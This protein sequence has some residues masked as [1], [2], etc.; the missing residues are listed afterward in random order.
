MSRKLDRQTVLALM[1]T[2]EVCGA[3]FSE[4]AA[5]LIVLDLERYADELLMMALARCRREL[6]HRLTLADIIERID[7]GRPG[8]EEAWA[9]IGSANEQATLVATEEAWQAHAVVSLRKHPREPSLLE[10]DPIAARKAFLECYARL[11]AVARAQGAPPKWRAS[12]GR[13]QAARL[14]ALR[15]AVERGQ[16]DPASAAAL[17]PAHESDTLLLPARSAESMIEEGKQRT[18][19]ILAMLEVMNKRPVGKSIDWQ[20]EEDR[21]SEAAQGVLEL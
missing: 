7:D 18:A 19:E 8:A 9:L 6:K 3:T 17:L 20:A 16:M 11:V 14:P 21:L 5:E 2:A 1:A 13:D 10:S 4:V 15:L 12:L